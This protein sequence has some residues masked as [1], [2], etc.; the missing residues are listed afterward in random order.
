MAFHSGFFDAVNLDRTYTAEDFTTYLSSLICNGILDTYGDNF[1]LTSTGEG[2]QVIV[3]TGKAW[4]NGHYFVNDEPYLMDFAGWQDPTFPRYIA[5]II[6]CDTSDLV[7]NVWLDVAL[8]QPAEN[9]T[10]PDIPTSETRT[11]LFLYAVRLNPGAPC[12]TE[13]DWFDYRAD[14]NV[15]GYC[16]CILGKCKVSEMQSQLARVLNEAEEL[17]KKVEIL[18]TKVDDLDSNVVETGK[19]G[20]NINYILYSND[21]LLLHGTGATYDYEIGESPFFENENIKKLVVSEGITAI[22]KSVFERCANMATASFPSTLT[23]IGERAF[24]MYSNGGLTSLTIPESVTTLGEKAFANQ[25]I[26]SVVLPETLTTLG[27]YIFMDCIKLKNVRVECAEVPQFCFTHSGLTSLTLSHNV[28]TIGSNAFN[29]T[30]LQELT[31]EGS[32]ADWSAVTKLNNWDNNIG[33]DN[34]HKLNKIICSDGFMIYDSEN[35]EWEVGE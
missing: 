3:G 6:A 31:Y 21:R 5:I 20:E 24:F 28:K 19:I 25:K 16:K 10:L 13:N 26:E 4:I 32:L 2:R 7:R 18:Q 15:C 8:G 11:N 33:T 30:P 34:P 29:Y 22:G 1:S 12:I 27:T 17:A 14:E 35:S 9:P 23:S